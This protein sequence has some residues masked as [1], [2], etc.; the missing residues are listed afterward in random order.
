VRVLAF[1]L[2]LTASGWAVGVDGVIRQHGVIPGIGDGLRRMVHNRDKIM[3]KTEEWKPDLVVME[4]VA[5][6]MNKSYA[7][8]NAGMAFMVRAEMFTDGWPYLLFTASSIKKFA[9]GSG[10]AKKEQILKEVFKRWGHDC[11]TND[12]ADAVAIAYIGMA[13]LGDWQTTTVP[14]REVVEQIRSKNLKVLSSLSSA[15]QLA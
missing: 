1:D 2:S 7:K 11:L 3:T 5:F 14:Q 4:D 6:S 13:L 8:E 15:G 9:A 10:A 12:Q